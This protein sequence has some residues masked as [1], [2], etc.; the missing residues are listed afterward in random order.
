MESPLLA[1]RVARPLEFVADDP[2][3]FRYDPQAQTAVW[4][5]TG[6]A[7]AALHCTSGGS[8][9]C[10]AYGTYCTTYAGTGS[11]SYCDS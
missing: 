3:D 9:K 1:F 11:K 2:G 7:I 6:K 5:G 4:T 8:R 10:N